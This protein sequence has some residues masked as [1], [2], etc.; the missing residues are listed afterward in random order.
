MT[1]YGVSETLIRRAA[2]AYRAGAWEEAESACSEPSGRLFIDGRPLNVTL[3]PLIH[4]LFPGAK[5]ILM[6]R[7]PR[8]VLLSCLR[9]RFAMNAASFQFLA[10]ETAARY[11][12]AVMALVEAARAR[13]PLAVHAVRYED[14]V[15]DLR[16]TAGKLL[17]FLGLPW[18]DD[19]LNHVEVARRRHIR[20]PIRSPLV[21]P[22]H[23]TSLGQWRYFEPQLTPVLPLLDEWVRRY[24]YWGSILSSSSY[25]ERSE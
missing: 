7:D 11:Y 9:E 5:I 6:M 2:A 23:R 21:P 19:V 13:L 15:N 4:R 12:D 1:P 17:S 10:P 8:D 16:G 18:S 24:D 22:V 20:T 14:V 25:A 3:L